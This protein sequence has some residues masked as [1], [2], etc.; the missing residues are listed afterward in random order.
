MATL[1]ALKA[2]ESIEAAVVYDRDGSI[3]AKYVRT[4][5]RNFRPPQI[6]AKEIV[7]ATRS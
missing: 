3:F 5:V 7:E 6:L 1:R 2:V 4:D